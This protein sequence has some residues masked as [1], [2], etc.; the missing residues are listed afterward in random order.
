[1]GLI[2][3]HSILPNKNPSPKITSMIKHLNKLYSQ[4]NSSRN[5]F[6]KFSLK[7]TQ[8][9]KS[10]KELYKEYLGNNFLGFELVNENI[11]CALENYNS[12]DFWQLRDAKMYDNFK[13]IYATLPKGKFFGPFGLL[14][15]LQK[16]NN[17]IDWLASLLNNDTSIFKNK[18]LS[19][20]LLY[21]DCMYK[22]SISEHKSGNPYGLYS[23]EDLCTDYYKGNRIDNFCK[24]DT[25][26]FK[27]TGDNSPFEQKPLE[28]TSLNYSLD[29]PLYCITT[30]Y[31]Q[32]IILIKNSPATEPLNI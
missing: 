28:I 10:N 27:L 22:T 20:A 11:L 14:H 8:S 32:Y 30:D 12:P 5:I 31:V 7:L 23:T 18:V 2:Y 9:I 26:I 19:I 16:R 21:K 15:T 17:D 25:T 29:I 4:K 3:L 24:S 13:R 1:M 6:K